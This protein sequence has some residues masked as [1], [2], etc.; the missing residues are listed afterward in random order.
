MAPRL[1]NKRRQAPPTSPAA[2]RYVGY[3]QAQEAA[4]T[5]FIKEQ[6]DGE[7]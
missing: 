2:F 5:P 7:S 4:T 6:R 1:C 3:A